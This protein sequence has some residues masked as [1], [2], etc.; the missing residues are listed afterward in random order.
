M[1]IGAGSW[2]NWGGNQQCRPVA[3]EDL[4]SELEV[5]EAIRA[6]AL[7]G[8]TV[9]VVGSGHSFTDIACTSGRLLRI[10]GLDRVVSIDHDA[11]TVTV[12]AGIKLWQLNRELALRGLALANLG[13]I[14]RQTLAGA[15][16]T[17]THGTGAKLGGLAALVRGI[18]LVTA[19]GEVLHCSADEEPDI[20]ACA[21]VSLGALGVI[22]RYTLQCVPAFRL[23]SLENVCSL[24]EVVARFDEIVDSNDHVDGYWWPHTEVCTLKC[25]NRTEDPVRVKSPAKQW[26]D[27]ILLANYLFGAITTA[28]RLRSSAVPRLMQFTTS[29]LGRSEK[30]D[31]SHRVFC[32][33]RL[34]RFVEME[35]ELPRAE[36]SKTLLRV[37]DLIESRRLPVDFPVELRATAADDIPLS[38]ANGRES[39]YLAVHLSAG[40]PFEEYFHGV[41]AIMDDVAGR[42]H[43]GK[44][45]FQTAATLAPRYPDWERF[46]GVRARLDP[47][48]RFRNDYLDRVLGPV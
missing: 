19:D 32:S 11:M 8:Q 7:A 26:R 1:G 10:D 34:V 24:D 22:T 36:L 6:A 40:R 42:P 30:V 14:D 13:D 17:G 38:T 33:R 18:D 20:F 16:A 27:E 48:G 25:N 21:R 29:Q 15:I 4:A 31:E 43:W 37:R 12:E 35:Y 46:R 45:H 23:H 44:M 41:E 47:D 5:V 39:A 2:R 9:K 28:G 3:V